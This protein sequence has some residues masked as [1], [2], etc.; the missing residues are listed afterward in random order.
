M[1][2]LVADPIAPDGIELLKQRFDVDV[3]VGLKPAELLEIIGAY[4]ALV[5]R[6]E[7]KVTAEVIQA[8]ANLQVIGR[9]G[10]GVDNIDVP[11]ATARGIVVVNAPTGNNIAAA[12]HTVAM[13][14]SLARHI[15]QANASLKAGEWKRSKFVGL[16]LRNKTLGVV[17]LGKIGSEVSRRA[18]GLEMRVVGFDPFI[19]PDRAKSLGV[20]L[21]SLNDLLAESDFVTV[22]TPLTDQTKALIGA[23]E[24]ALMKPTA[25]IINCAR[26]GIIDEQALYDAVESGRIAGAA[27]DVFTAEPAVDNILLKSDKIVV[28]PHLG[29]S[30]E[31][32]QVNVAIDVA[33]QIVDVLQDRPARY[34]VNA[35]FIPPEAAPILAP[36]LLLGERLGRMAT[37]L[38]EG[39]VG[40][41]TITVS[42]EIAELTTTPIRTAVIKGL[43][44]PVSE[45][46][47]NMVN[48]NVI[49]RERGLH[50]VEQKALEP[51]GNYTSLLTVTVKTSS[52]TTTCGGAMMRDEPHIVLIDGYWIDLAVSE[53]YLLLARHRDRPG[54]IGALGNLLGDNDINIS[55]MQVGREAPRGP[56]IMVLGLDDQIP[57]AV[58][59]RIRKLEDLASAKLVRL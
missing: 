17:G 49:A 42:G 13:M 45:Q 50:V 6:S 27:I 2:I 31:E 44:E 39:Q 10:V 14:L 48:A 57:A 22:H 53:G 21:R 47:V 56:A 26:G 16:E 32:A 41:I 3:R 20:E 51:A 33:E 15:P 40:A 28:T 19:T 43:L 5:V 37:Q 59:D 8:G 18:L 11:A 24:I 52:G 30:T 58:M 55:F 4:A 35:P 54:M 25:R 23:E 9:A 38:A 1:R 34:A 7:T 36:Y 12:E 46:Q 29:A